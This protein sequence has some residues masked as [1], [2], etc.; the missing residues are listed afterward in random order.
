MIE[1][2]H[3]CRVN[4][5]KQAVYKGHFDKALTPACFEDAA[6]IS[7]RLALAKLNI[8]HHAY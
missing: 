3:T 4:P 6:V 8:I 7:Y 5:Q 2:T 1:F